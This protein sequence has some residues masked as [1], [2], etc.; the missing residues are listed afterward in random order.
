M[1]SLKNCNINNILIYKI[2]SSTWGWV[3]FLSLDF[4][5]PGKN[6]AQ[7]RPASN[8]LKVL[9]DKPLQTSE[10][11]MVVEYLPNKVH[12]LETEPTSLVINLLQL[13]RKRK[14]FTLYSR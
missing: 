5:R 1:I 8:L 4:D 12:Y 9:R 14:I 3:N 10:R 6:V 13:Y 2:T 11:R 7:A